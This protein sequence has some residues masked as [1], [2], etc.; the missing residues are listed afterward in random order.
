MLL[1]NHLSDLCTIVASESIQPYNDYHH[2]R[3][4][5]SNISMTSASSLLT[6]LN[7]FDNKTFES[8]TETSEY[9]ASNVTDNN[10]DLG[11]FSFFASKNHINVKFL[12][13]SGKIGTP[14]SIGYLWLKKRGYVKVE[15]GILRKDKLKF[16]RYMM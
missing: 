2:H 16:S 8:S 11:I 1:Y 14:L 10:N 6:K 4:Y 7:A 5:V 12:N 13:I 9:F 3:K 15:N